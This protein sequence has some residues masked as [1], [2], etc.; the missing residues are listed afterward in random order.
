VILKTTEPMVRLARGQDVW[1]WDTEGR[2]YLDMYGGHAVCS[3]GHAHPKLVEAI[4]RQA[5]TLLFYSTAADLEIREAAAR[6]LATERH[7]RVFFVNSG[8]EA[9]ENAMKLARLVTGRERFVAFD[10][11]FHG[12]TAGAASLKD[13]FATGRFGVVP[14]VDATVAAA[15]VEPIQS[16]AGVRTASADFFVGLRRACDAAG[17]LLIYDEVQ[18][19]AGRTGTML[20]AGRHGVWP[21]LICL[22]KGIGG[23]FPVSA[24]LMTEAIASRVKPGD[25]GSTFGGGPLASAAVVAT[26]A[27]L[28]D[29]RLI[30]NAAERGRQLQQ[31][32]GAFG[33]GLLLGVRAR[34]G[35]AQRLRQN[36]FL[37]GG[38]NDP[39]V[40]RL[41]PPLTISREHCDAFAEAFHQHG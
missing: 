9:I 27:I 8:A 31:S 2:R 23:G 37:V 40:I 30:E 17:A 4:E 35:T 10:G 33:E 15:V 26:T 20:W 32:I 24:V 13:P 25:L 11:C 28:R 1:V 12:R 18:T 29:E 14:P 6:A 36:G 21:D 34:P 38:S 41:L 5:R 16:M 19:G 22:A 7:P 3:V 39:N